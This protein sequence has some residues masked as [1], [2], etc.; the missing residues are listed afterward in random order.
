MQTPAKLSDI[1]IVSLPLVTHINSSPEEIYETEKI[2][3]KKQLPQLCPY[4][5]F[6]KSRI[7]NLKDLIKMS[8][9]ISSSQLSNDFNDDA[10]KDLIDDATCNALVYILQKV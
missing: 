4:Q 3:I 10:T 8:A 6:L 1:N 9:K 2:N 7:L 5:E